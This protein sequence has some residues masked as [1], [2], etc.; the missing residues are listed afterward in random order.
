MPGMFSIE[1]RLPAFLVLDQNGRL[2]YATEQ[3][4]QEVPDIDKGKIGFED[5]FEG[6]LFSDFTTEHELENIKDT[7]IKTTLTFK[8]GSKSSLEYLVI[9]GSTKNEDGSSN[10]YLIQH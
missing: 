7:K 5:L 4:R 10:I 9:A 3:I 1:G 2:E 6:K 8:N